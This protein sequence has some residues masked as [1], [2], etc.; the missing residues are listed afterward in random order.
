[1]VWIRQGDTRYHLLESCPYL[2]EIPS[3]AEREI[4]VREARE[5]EAR[6]EGLARCHHCY[7]S[8][9]RTA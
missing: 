6:H 2:T 3:E 7:G 4:P 5:V 1:M 8:A 9:G